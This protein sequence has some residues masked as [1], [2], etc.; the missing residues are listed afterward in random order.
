MIK[1]KETDFIPGKNGFDAKGP[2]NNGDK[3]PHLEKMPL[4]EQLNKQKSNVSA[5]TSLLT[6][7]ENT[8]RLPLAK[9]KEVT[10]HLKKALRNIRN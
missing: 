9:R 10:E 4:Q 6:A 2:E 1:E 7:L 3:E 5:L 8:R